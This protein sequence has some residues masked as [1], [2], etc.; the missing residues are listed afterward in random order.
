M[1]AVVSGS[2]Q[3]DRAPAGPQG[4][5]GEVIRQTVLQRSKYDPDERRQSLRKNRRERGV[6]VYIPAEEML[7]ANRTVF[8]PA[9]KYRVWGRRGGTVLVRLYKGGEE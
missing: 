8:G 6:W 5:T 9:P 4:A 2:S 1:A 3:P 7:K